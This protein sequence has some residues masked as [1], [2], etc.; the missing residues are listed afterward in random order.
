MDSGKKITSSTL[1][2][3]EAIERK[4]NCGD[5]ASNRSDAHSLATPWYHRKI[6][7]TTATHLRPAAMC[8]MTPTGVSIFN[9]NSSVNL[10]RPSVWWGAWL[11]AGGQAT[12]EWSEIVAFVNFK[13]ARHEYTWPKQTILRFTFLKNGEGYSPSQTSTSVGVLQTTP[14]RPPLS[15]PVFRHRSAVVVVVVVVQVE[16][17]TFEEQ[18]TQIAGRC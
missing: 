13:I 15:H 3:G 16:H 17:L 5:V 6:L 8:E 4:A 9:N 11:T 10:S 12:I 7:W 1:S 2:G 14:L 18:L